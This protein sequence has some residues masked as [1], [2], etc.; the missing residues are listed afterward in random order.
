MDWKHSTFCAV[1]PALRLDYVFRVI[2]ADLVVG[3]VQRASSSFQ[4]ALLQAVKL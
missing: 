3:A 2:S 1:T 4:Q